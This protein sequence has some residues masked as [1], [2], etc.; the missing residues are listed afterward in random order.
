MKGQANCLHQ[1]C[2]VKTLLDYSCLKRV[3]TAQVQVAR[4]EMEMR[5]DLNRPPFPLLLL[6]SNSNIQIFFS[7]AAEGYTLCRLLA[8]C[9]ERR[10]YILFHTESTHSSSMSMSRLISSSRLLTSIL[11]S[12]LTIFNVSVTTY[13]F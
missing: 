12:P 2:E 13:G 6:E 11:R 7:I 9:Q 8:R 5:S 4:L 10:L 3:R 1:P